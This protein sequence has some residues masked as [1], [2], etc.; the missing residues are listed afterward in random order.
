MGQ[1]LLILA[2]KGHIAADLDRFL[3]A[4]GTSLLR[5][6]YRNRGTPCPGG[7][8]L[9]TV[10]QLIESVRGQLDLEQHGGRTIEG[11]GV[12]VAER[13]LAMTCAIG[14]TATHNK[15][16]DRLRSLSHI[17]TIRLGSSR[18][19]KCVVTTYPSAR[20]PS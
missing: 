15:V 2:D 19:L 20:A 13:I 17:G 5:P 6:S 18:V 16:N 9:K 3:V 1:A 11:I 12:R 8:L 10:R 14:H 7:T 4:H